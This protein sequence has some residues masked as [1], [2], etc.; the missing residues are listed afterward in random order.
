MDI[1]KALTGKTIVVTRS[2]DQVNDLACLLQGH[3]ATVVEFPVIDIVPPASWD[4]LDEALNRIQTYHWIIFSSTNAVKFFAERIRDLGSSISALRGI[5]ICCVGPKTAEAFRAS[6]IAVDLIPDNYTAEGLLKAFENVEIKG[7]RFLLPRAK[8]AR[9]LI[10]D[11]LRSRGAIVTVATVY[12]NVKPNVDA[13]NL[14]E[15][16]RTGEIDCVSFTS[17]STVRN[18]VEILGQ[19]EYKSL[20]QNSSIACIGPVTAKTARDLGMDVHVMPQEH[21]IPALVDAMVAYF[22]KT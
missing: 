1:E 21:T 6:G 22:K 5:K 19:K 9:D 3:G 11:T 2:S 14:K 8:E 13:T 16:F 4:E 12:E 18:F 17:S 10:P 20:L 15:L 7:E